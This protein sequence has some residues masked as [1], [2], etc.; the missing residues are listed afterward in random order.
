VTRAAASR[1]SRGARAA[2][3][4]SVLA[5]CGGGGASARRPDILLVSIDTLRADRLSC[6][7]NERPT[8]PF[9]DSLAATGARAERA[10]STTSWTL[11]AHLSMLTG[12]PISAHGICDE[13]L[14]SLRGADGEIAAPELHGEFLPEVL[15]SAGYR[16]AGFYTWKYLEPKFGFGPGFETYERV[17]GPVAGDG[18][19]PERPQRGAVPGKPGQLS[20][21]E[22]R[23]LRA[24]FNDLQA[25]TAAAL[26]DRAAAWLDERRAEREQGAEAPYFLFLHCIDV[27][28][29][30]AAP[31]PFR[32]RFDPDYEG[33]ID[34]TRVT[35]AGSPVV[36]DMPARDLEH[37]IALYDGEIAWVDSQLARLE[38]LIEERGLARDLVVAV[39]SDH[40][41]EF[42]EH[43]A[44][45]H[46]A[47]LHPESLRVPLIWNW[48]GRIAPGT[49]LER[50]VGLVDLAPT[51]LGLVG[52]RPPA[53]AA[54]ADLSGVLRGALDPGE[55]LYL[56][57]LFVFQ[58]VDV[59]LHRLSL[60]EGGRQWLLERRPGNGTIDDRYETRAHDL[61]ASVAGSGSGERA[62]PGSPE[63]ARALELLARAR[64]AI[65]AAR[66]RAPVRPLRDGALSPI[67][68]EELEALGYV[69]A[70]VAESAAGDTGAL[71]VDGCVWL[72]Q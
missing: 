28:D 3:L 44:K 39:T 2:A 34:G 52:L 29:D 16:T 41:E 14:W 35:G 57:E 69:G 5:A 13:R 40:G 25:P 4:L 56:G 72:A 7:G 58:D 59:P 42:F 49:V 20:A 55:R 48:P 36:R 47:Q 30:Y 31:E 18:A 33:P 64:A 50:D 45:T 12:L 21:E 68:R 70:G 43:G 65:D 66:A 38:S 11:P 8:S 26:V 6:Y 62:K 15:Q 54:G 53:G 22:R 27:H 10:W 9:L 19:A 32:S 60:V 23:D 67:E 46:R 61:T 37:L 71:C 51:L 17:G 1:P 24:A 63:E